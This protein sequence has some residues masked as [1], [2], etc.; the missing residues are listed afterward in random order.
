MAI[1]HDQEVVTRIL[2]AIRKE[3]D[4]IPKELTKFKLEMN[5]GDAVKIECSFYPTCKN[6]NK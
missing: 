6:E 3:F 1:S 4:D 2:D 5:L